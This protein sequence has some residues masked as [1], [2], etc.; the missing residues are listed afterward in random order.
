MVL[1]DPA[2]GRV[3]DALD[4]LAEAAVPRELAHRQPIGR[5]TIHD[6]TTCVSERA[7]ASPSQPYTDVRQSRCHCSHHVSK[8][9]GVT[10]RL[11]A[12][13]ETSRDAHIR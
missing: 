4:P 8:S 5:L 12:I 6:V 13:E 7:N 10:D 2:D 3:A 11:C 1:P 9:G